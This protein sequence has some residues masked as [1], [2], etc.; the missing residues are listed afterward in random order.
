MRSGKTGGWVDH[1]SEGNKALFKEI[2]GDMLERLG[3]EENSNW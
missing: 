3:Y 2:S 1:F